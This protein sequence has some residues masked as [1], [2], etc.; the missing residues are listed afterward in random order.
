MP[1]SRVP[2]D[3]CCAHGGCR[4]SAPCISSELMVAP[5]ASEATSLIV[6]RSLLGFGSPTNCAM[7]VET[8][9]E[10][11]AIAGETTAAVIADRCDV[12]AAEPSRGMKRCRINADRLGAAWREHVR[13]LERRRRGTFRVLRL[14][15]R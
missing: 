13:V 15:E 12:P 3:A 9:R 10:A 7:S 1:S 8:A 11:T 14:L 6:R 2:P 4:T 5:E